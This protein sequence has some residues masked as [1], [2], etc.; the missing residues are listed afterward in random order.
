MN[1]SQEQSDDTVVSD[2]IVSDRIEQEI[3]LQGNLAS[4]LPEIQCANNTHQ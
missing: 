3:T 1:F 2:N 4:R